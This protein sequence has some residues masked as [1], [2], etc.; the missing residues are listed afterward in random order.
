MQ[1]LLDSRDNLDKLYRDAS[2]S[3]TALERSHHCTMS[4]L[5]RH[6]DEL[7]ISQNEVSRLGRLLPSKDSVIR[8]LCASKKLVSR[9]L[10]VVRRDSKAVC[11]DIKVLEDDCA[12]MKAWCDKAMD[13]VVCAGQILM[14]RPGVVVPNDLV[15]DVLAA[16]A[17]SSNPSASGDPVDKVPRDDAPAQ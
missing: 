8:E 3:L 2:I 10:E 16:S 6:R 1:K 7:K 14:K 17:T 9:E 4:E 12:I 13:K 15:A 11:R 5:E